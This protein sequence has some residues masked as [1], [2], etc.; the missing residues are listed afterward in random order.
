MK[1]TNGV[2]SIK[3]GAGMSKYNHTLLVSARWCRGPDYSA[4]R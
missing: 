3:R 4:W 1:A 2:V